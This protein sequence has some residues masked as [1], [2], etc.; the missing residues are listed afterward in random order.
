MKLAVSRRVSD[1]LTSWSFHCHLDKQVFLCLNYQL[2]MWIGWVIAYL[3]PK[4]SALVWV[5]Q[6]FL[7][8]ISKPQAFSKLQYY[9]LPWIKCQS[10]NTRAYSCI[11]L[12]WIFYEE[13]R[14]IAFLQ[15]EWYWSKVGSKTMGISMIVHFS[16]W[17]PP[18]ILVLILCN[19]LIIQRKPVLMLNTALFTFP[20][21][22]RS[23][24]QFFVTRFS[25]WS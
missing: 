24:S 1:D 18:N 17:C 16:G 19:L 4:L 23:A 7:H 3:N 2:P 15:S 12:F 10:S 8:P 25:G 21:G 11:H 6:W 9:H 14:H 20:S 22:T 5:Y 13:W